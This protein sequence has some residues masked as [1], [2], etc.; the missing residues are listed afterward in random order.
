MMDNDTKTR[1]L[2]ALGLAESIAMR[3]REM[4]D[5]AGRTW[6]AEEF[7]NLA[8]TLADIEDQLYRKGEYSPANVGRVSR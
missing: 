7:A 5:G 8:R 3:I 4:M 6:N 2:E 1:A